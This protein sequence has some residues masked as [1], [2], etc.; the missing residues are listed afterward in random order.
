M[1]RSGWLAC[2]AVIGALAVTAGDRRAIAAVLAVAA[3][4]LVTAALF[5]RRR[6]L[7]IAS[8]I[9][10]L[11]IVVRSVWIPTASD[12]AGAPSGDGPWEM[13]VE[14]IGSPRDGHQVAT[15]RT[16]EDGPSGF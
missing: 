13:L 14:S 3:V 1:R 8:S 15:L 10:V 6:S 12:L 16:L 9:G 7:L 5:R 11:A 2:G 4:A